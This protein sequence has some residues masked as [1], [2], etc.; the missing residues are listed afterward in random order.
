MADQ[1]EDP[2]LAIVG[3]LEGRHFDALETLDLAPY[4]P[5]KLQSVNLLEEDL[6]ETSSLI[7]PYEIKTYR[8]KK[9]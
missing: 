7:A 2:I 5:S 9:G 1:A 8:L 4:L 6:E 3:L